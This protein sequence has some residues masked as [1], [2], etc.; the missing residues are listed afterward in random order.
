MVC[1]HRCTLG[2]CEI[3]VGYLW[4]AVQY[5]CPVHHFCCKAKTNRI[6]LRYPRSRSHS[7]SHPCPAD[8][9]YLPNLPGY[10]DMLSSEA[11]PAQECAARCLAASIADSDIKAQAFY[12][13]NEKNCACSK[14]ACS[15]VVSHSSYQAY[16]IKAP[17][18]E[19][20]FDRSTTSSCN[21]CLP[22]ITSFQLQDHSDTTNQK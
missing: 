16:D 10:P 19:C 2:D 11:D 7:R 5:P 13:K 20:A 15:S 14:G 17:A 1:A 4:F 3:A 9:K 18:A 6:L 8:Y 12:L 22:C 21:D